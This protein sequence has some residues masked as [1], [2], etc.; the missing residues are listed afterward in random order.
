MEKGLVKLINEQIKLENQ[1]SNFYLKMA[2]FF[3]YKG[4][5]GLSN[6]YY[7]QSIEEREHMTM[8]IKFLNERG[9][10]VNFDFSSNPVIDEDIDML[11]SIELSLENEEI[12]TNSILEIY[13]QSILNKDYIT[14]K[15]IQWFIEEQ[16]LEEDKFRKLAD[17]IRIGGNSKTTQLIIEEKL[18]NLN[19]R[20]KK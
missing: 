7:S 16:R 17:K 9:E 19:E 13:N 11:S 4:F 18:L 6:L 8:F 3:D 2:S 10:K 15:F 14:S 5:E 1:A 20:L 12:V